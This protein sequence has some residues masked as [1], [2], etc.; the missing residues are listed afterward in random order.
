M[1]MVNFLSSLADAAHNVIYNFQITDAIDILVVA[2]IV[3]LILLLLKRTR[4]FFIV[5][6]IVVLFVVYVLAQAF[7]LSLTKSLF[8]YIFTFF[9]VIL[10]VIFQRELRSFFEWISVSIRNRSHRRKGVLLP[11]VHDVVSSVSEA[12]AYLAQHHIGALL[13]FPGLQPLGRF[14]EK[15]IDLEGKVSTPLLLSIF[16]ASSPGHDG[17]VVIEGDRII[18]FSVHLPLAEH[19]ERLGNIGTRHRS[20]LGLAERSDA[21]VVVVSEERGVV[22]VAR[23]GKL[24]ALKDPAD[25]VGVLMAFLNIE[26]NTKKKK[27]V[28]YAW[29]TRHTGEKILAL[30]VACVVWFMFSLQL[31][32]VNK[33]LSPLVEFRYLPKAYMVDQVLPQN[34]T[35]DVSGRSSDVSTLSDGDLHVVVDASTMTEGWG[36]VIVSQDIIQHPSSVSVVRFSPRIIT[37][38]IQKTQ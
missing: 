4:S 8:Q 30:V 35:V 20:A 24:K 1:N 9:I 18:K 27:V 11:D 34:I 3:Y 17:A 14:L 16:D 31:G 32:N 15:G 23:D 38:H 13:V 25:I 26:D 5:D 12:V 7:N 36:K 19:S 21:L 37:F 33:E 29:I 6:G 10:V 28:W 22:S 2:G